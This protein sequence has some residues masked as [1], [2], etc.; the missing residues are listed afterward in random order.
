MSN[1]TINVEFLAGTE[2]GDAIEE[3]KRNAEEWDVAYVCFKFNGTRFSIGRYACV[4]RCVEKY[5]EGKTF[6]A[7]NGKSC[8]RIH[9][10]RL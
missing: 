6:I 4:G 9:D 7:D 10:T 2:V 5:N 1:I 8:C 3:A